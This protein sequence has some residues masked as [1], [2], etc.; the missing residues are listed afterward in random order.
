MDVLFQNLSMDFLPK[1]GQNGQSENF[2]KHNARVSN[3]KFNLKF[4][5]YPL[6]SNSKTGRRFR[7]GF[8]KKN[9]HFWQ[10]LGEQ[11]SLE[12]WWLEESTVWIHTPLA[13]NFRLTMARIFGRWWREFSALH[14]ILCLSV[15]EA[16]F[17]LFVLS[18]NSS[19]SLLDPFVFL[20]SMLLH[21]KWISLFII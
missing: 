10:F 4:R 8:L 16:L 13:A 3:G 17:M 2:P 7:S 20:E 21:N 12:K 14:F 9:N 5:R 6:D 15:W 1:K 19:I 11:L 18:T